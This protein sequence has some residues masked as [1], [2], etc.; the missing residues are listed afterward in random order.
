ML[1]EYHHG[2]K[3][4]TPVR[5]AWHARKMEAWFR[6]VCTASTAGSTNCFGKRPFLTT[7]REVLCDEPS[8]CTS[9]SILLNPKPIIPAL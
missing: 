7:S 3:Y 2:T 9:R 5:L 6:A 1:E 4:A 8:L